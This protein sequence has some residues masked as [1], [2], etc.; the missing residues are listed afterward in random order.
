MTFLVWRQYRAQG[1]IAFVLLAAFAAVILVD[2]F[3]VAS[4]WHSVLAACS[5]RSGCLEQQPPLV[6][7]SVVDAVQLLGLLVPAVLGL[8]W[9]AP[10][11]AQELE[12]RTSDFAWAQ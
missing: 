6:S 7:Q 10:L 2:G 1:A 8:L 3:Q 12:S 9:G 4:H 5:G 11:V